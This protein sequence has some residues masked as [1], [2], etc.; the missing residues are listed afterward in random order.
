MSKFDQ[1]L[2]PNSTKLYDVYS[3]Y[4]GL[5]SGMI[6]DGYDSDN[7]ES[8]E[9]KKETDSKFSVKKLSIN[10]LLVE[11]DLG[12]INEERTKQAQLQK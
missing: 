9:I 1:N 2:D 10:D 11:H 8:E 5:F 6:N 7:K 4:Q 12:V 3:E